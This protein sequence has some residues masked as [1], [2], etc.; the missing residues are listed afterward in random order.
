[1]ETHSYP[2]GDTWSV[3]REGKRQVRDELERYGRFDSRVTVSEV[4]EM[5]GI[6]LKLRGHMHFQVWTFR[7]CELRVLSPR[8][9]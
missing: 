2:G 9:A 8:A 5:K 3:R 6:Q 7:F 1:M 4:T